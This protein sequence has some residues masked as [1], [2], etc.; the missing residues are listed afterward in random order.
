[1]FTGIIKFKSKLENIEFKD[2]DMSF[3]VELNKIDNLKLGDSIAINGT[4]LTIAEIEKTKCKFELINETVNRTSFKYLKNNYEVNIEDSLKPNDKLDGHLVY[5]D[6]DSTGKIIEL[7]KVGDA[8]IYTISF[9]KEFNPFLI[10]K[11]RI[12]VDGISLTVNNVTQDTFEIY[13]I[14]HTNKVTTL[15]NKKVGDILNLEYD[16]YL[17]ALYKWSKNEK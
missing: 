10:N 4:C 7:K 2:Y 1:M 9:P 3:W 15:E 8:Q 14:P 13:I 12:C 5:G 17:K 16:L 6:V 11:G